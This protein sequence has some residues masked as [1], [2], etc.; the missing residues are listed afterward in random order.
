MLDN[1]GND[2]EIREHQKGHTIT[3]LMPIHEI[4]LIASASTDG[5]MI[6][7]TMKDMKFK[8]AHTD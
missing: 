4:G 7:W 3:D 5:N 6:L 2:K 1:L 8:S